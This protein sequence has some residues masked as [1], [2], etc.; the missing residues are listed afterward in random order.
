METTLSGFKEYQQGTISAVKDGCFS[1]ESTMECTALN[2]GKFIIHIHNFRNECLP[3]KACGQW[4][5]ADND[6]EAVISFLKFYA[7]LL[8]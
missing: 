6:Y 1:R 8:A 4:V 7:S 5:K 2:F 3:L